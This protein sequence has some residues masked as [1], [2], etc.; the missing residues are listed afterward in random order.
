MTLLSE[1]KVSQ[2][3]MK[4]AVC[5]FHGDGNDDADDDLNEYDP[6]N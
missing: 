3:L 4:F 2:S 6:G 1:G 5:E